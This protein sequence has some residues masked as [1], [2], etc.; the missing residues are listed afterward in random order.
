[1]LI[2]HPA[3]AEAGVIGKP[4]EI[5]GEVVKAF[6]SL[7][8]GFVESEALRQEILAHARRRL[9]AAVAPKE[10]AFVASLPRTRSGKI[11]R[12]LLKAREMGLPEGDTSTLE[13]GG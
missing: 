2:E 1:M 5:V 3:V 4:D 10:I 8:Q 13:S 11:M 7:K 6:V 9:G 12:R